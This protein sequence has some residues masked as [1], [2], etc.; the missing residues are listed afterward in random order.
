M[1]IG[2]IPAFFRQQ[3]IS[4][5]AARQGNQGQDQIVDMV[6][7]KAQAS[8]LDAARHKVAELRDK[9]N[10]FINPKLEKIL[11]GFRERADRYRYSQE[12]LS[13]HQTNLEQYQRLDGQSQ[14][15][16]QKLTNT[17]A[18][19]GDP[20]LSTE[21]QEALT[22]QFTT[23]KN[24]LSDVNRQMN[25]LVEQYNSY[26]K[27]PFSVLCGEE[28]DES[29][30]RENF[31]EKL[32]GVVENWKAEVKRSNESLMDYCERYGLTPF[33]F[34][35][36]YD[37]YFGGKNALSAILL[38]AKQELGELMKENGEDPNALFDERV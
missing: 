15:L 34:E 27:N 36:C 10:E 30:T 25:S 9:L 31:K 12:Q 3:P 4:A 5:A 14:E 2:Q 28:K 22:D 11:Q 32:G 26:G 38:Q 29:F 13:T 8:P 6:N 19:L 1:Y 20:S 7:K 23:L 17:Q 33:E 18:A 16:Q 24:A 35:Q 37:A 21:E